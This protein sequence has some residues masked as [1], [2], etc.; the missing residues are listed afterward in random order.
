MKNVLSTIAPDRLQIQT[1]TPFKTIK[2]I[3]HAGAAFLGE[4]SS[5]VIGDYLSGANRVLPTSATAG[6]SSG[7]S[8]IDFLKKVYFSRTTK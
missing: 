4:H 1:K 8:V 6:F 5:V 7:P 2:H 3:K